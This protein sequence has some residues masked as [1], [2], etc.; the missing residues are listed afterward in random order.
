MTVPP[1]RNGS[2]LKKMSV[3]HYFK[4]RGECPHRIHIN[5][6]NNLAG[7]LQYMRNTFM[8][9]VPCLSISLRSDTHSLIKHKKCHFCCIQ[10]SVD[11]LVRMNIVVTLTNKEHLL[12][13]KCHP[14]SKGSARRAN[15]FEPRSPPLLNHTTCHRPMPGKTFHVM[16]PDYLE[17]AACLKVALLETSTRGRHDEGASSDS[18]A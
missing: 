15:L 10:N 2:T 5:K 17:S 4:I 9:L 13:K 14:P 18:Y 6:Q 16:I 3:P 1:E 11:L 7:V 12:T 8:F